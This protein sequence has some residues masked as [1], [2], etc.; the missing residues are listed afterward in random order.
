MQRAEDVDR[1]GVVVAVSRGAGYESSL[2]TSLRHAKLLRTSGFADAIKQLSDLKVDAIAGLKPS[3][4]EY[5]KDHS[6]VRVLDGRFGVVQQAIGIPIGKD[7]AAAYLRSFMDEIKQSGFVARS[8]ES[9]R[10]SGLTMT[11]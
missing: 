4:V 10:A 5:A 6:A 1:D 2:V 3:L 11:Q 8:I 9:N 7:A